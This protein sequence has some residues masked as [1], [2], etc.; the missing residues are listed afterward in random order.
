LGKF[1]SDI[2]GLACAWESGLNIIWALLTTIN[3]RTQSHPERTDKNTLGEIVLNYADSRLGSISKAL[4]PARR[5]SKL[6]KTLAADA[7]GEAEREVSLRMHHLDS[8]LHLQEIPLELCEVWKQKGSP[9]NK[10]GGINQ[11]YLS[12]RPTDV[13]CRIMEQL[14]LASASRDAP[15]E[16]ALVKDSEEN[17]ELFIVD[18]PDSQ[19]A[20]THRPEHARLKII[21]F[22]QHTVSYCPLAGKE[23]PISFLVAPHTK[24]RSRRDSHERGDLHIVIAACSFGCDAILERPHHCQW[25][26][27]RPTKTAHP[28]NKPPSVR[29]R[30]LAGTASDRSYS[31][32]SQVLRKAPWLASSTPDPIVPTLAAIAIQA[33]GTN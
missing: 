26:C 13:G 25:V 28:R 21:L 9:F 4:S 22:G 2:Q 30:R 31:P 23:L 12:D 5:A 1:L 16:F 24:K 15:L 6:Y 32:N 33:A 7:W 14:G 10:T 17:E 18:G 11:A 3:D 19:L 29:H 8:P 20:S 27:A